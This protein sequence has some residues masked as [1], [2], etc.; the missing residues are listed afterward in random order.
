MRVPAG[1][2]PSCIRSRKGSLP[3][4]LT[5]ESSGR[6][7][8]HSAPAST[9]SIASTVRPRCVTV[10]LERVVSLHVCYFRPNSL[11]RR[12][13]RFGSSSTCLVAFPSSGRVS[14]GGG[15][16]NRALVGSTSACIFPIPFSSKS[17]WHRPVVRSCSRINASSRRIT[18]S[19]KASAFT[20]DAKSVR[21]SP[22]TISKVGSPTST[23]AS[24]ALR[25]AADRKT[26]GM[27]ICK[28]TLCSAAG[29]HR[30]S[31]S[32]DAGGPSAAAKVRRTT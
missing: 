19:S 5:T 29:R 26:F 27:S 8:C 18:P 12:P 15:K 24:V 30:R 11:L 16:R 6:P 21:S 32:H 20:V 1:D 3:C 7:P 13:P 22:R 14:A 31:A 17:H 4:R 10:R 25:V 28:L 2:L 9:P 23:C